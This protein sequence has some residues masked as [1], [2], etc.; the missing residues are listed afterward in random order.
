MREM[1]KTYIFAA[2]AIVLIVV[3]LISSPG[4]ITPNAF[5]DQGESFYPDFTDPNIARTLEVIDYDEASGTARPFKVTFKNGLWT[6]PSHYDYP[7][8][9]AERLAKTAAGV[10]DIKKDEF[11]SDNLSEH[12][13]FNLIDPLSET[14]GLTGRGQRIKIL[15]ESDQ[16]LADYIIGKEVEGRQK[17]RYVRLPNQNRVFAV[18]MDINLSTRFE[19]WI[20]RDL[21]KLT[22][23]KINRVQI[24]DY[25]VNERNLQIETKDNID[26]R[27][28]DF[29]WKANRMSSSQKVD[30]SAIDNLLTSISEL[31]VVGVRPKP[32]GFSASLKGDGSQQMTRNDMVNL[33]RI[34]FYLNRDGT[35]FSNEGELIVYSDEGLEFTLHFGE[36]LSGGGLTGPS[37]QTDNKN[38]AGSNRYLFITAKFNEN[39]FMKPPDPPTQDQFNQYQAKVDNGRKLGEEFNVRFADWYYVI[40]GESFAKINVKRSSLVVTN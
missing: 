8:D 1:K 37:D 12:E 35:I 33:Q 40:S 21:M 15:D 11:R 2:A 25:S 38:Q 4:R 20:E 24:K 31:M 27:Y 36:V 39:Y 34:G 5:L 23:E 32:E 18:R 28:D 29:V 19:D 3:A 16:V 6:I 13:K 10:I 30:S 9:G 14:S 22:K 7:A 26:L 17:F